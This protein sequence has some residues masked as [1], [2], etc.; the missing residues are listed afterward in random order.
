VTRGLLRGAAFALAAV[1]AAAAA[2][3]PAAPADVAAT[4]AGV[5]EQRTVQLTTTG[6]RSGKPH[7]VTVWFMVDGPVVYLNTLDPD[8]DWVRNAQ[9]T[10]AVRLDF[11]DAA[12]EGELRTVTDPALQ[13]KIVQA[14]RDKYWVAWAGGLLGQGP[15]QTYVIESLR[16]AGP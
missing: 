15:K 9:K 4:L 14:L 8:R 5:R 1:A 13:T 3:A 16:S 7:T 12:F 11:G 10:P 6:R 2:D